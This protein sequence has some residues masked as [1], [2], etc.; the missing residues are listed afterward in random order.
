M[1][2]SSESSTLTKLK[3]EVM[4]WLSNI[5]GDEQVPDF[6]INP[7]TIEFLHQ[8]LQKTQQYDH[9]L[10]LITSDFKQKSIE[11]NAEAQ[12]LSRILQRL[13]LT[14][15]SLS[16]SGSKSLQALSKLGMLLEVKDTSN[17][18]YMLAL[19]HLE[20][21]VQRVEDEAEEETEELRKLVRSYRQTLHQCNSLQKALSEAKTK[22]AEDAE[23]NAKKDHEITY[24]LQKERNYKKEIKKME[25]QLSHTKIEAS[26]FHESLVKKSEILKDIKSQ[27]EPLQAE[28]ESYS[29][30]PPDL[31]M[32]KF[33]VAEYQM[34]VESLNK[35]FLD[36]IGDAQM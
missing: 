25:N 18:S 6:E 21:E 35:Q 10:Q 24:F 23:L 8:L 15:E 33:K 28:L 12:R 17:T 4:A 30:L 29:V 26:L 3:Q 1:E 11:Y 19:Q 27:L 20:D 32:A 7:Q 36:C 9:H 16:N 14:P 22:E 5:F 34:K 13:Q 31:D 2:S